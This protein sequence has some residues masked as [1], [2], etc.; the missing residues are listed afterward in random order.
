MTDKA[1]TYAVILISVHNLDNT[2]A[3]RI[4]VSADEFT[5]IAKK[6]IEELKQRGFELILHGAL[7]SE[8]KADWAPASA[9]VAQD[10]SN[11]KAAQGIVCCWTG[12]GASIAA[13]KVHGIRAAL[14]N[15]AATAKG[16]RRWN[17]A[18]IL[19]L[20]LRSTSE[21]ELIEILDAWFQSPT[22][23]EKSDRENIDFIQKIE[24]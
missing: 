10:V 19:A 3:P 24:S 8:E 14:C 16:A 2:K 15:D 9:A 6:L 18:N 7:N 4:A 22:S 23:S 17:D 13:N 1:K 5:G 11:G 12:T 20:S 21:A